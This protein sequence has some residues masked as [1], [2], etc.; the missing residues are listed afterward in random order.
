MTYDI[1]GYGEP[2]HRSD[3]DQSDRHA[4]DLQIYDRQQL[5]RS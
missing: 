4:D 3:T 5:F 1:C 2:L